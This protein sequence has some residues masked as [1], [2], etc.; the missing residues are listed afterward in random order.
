LVGGWISVVVGV[1]GAIM[2]FVGDDPP[3]GFDDALGASA[4]GVAIALPGILA[5]VALRRKPSLLVAG[6]VIALP[7]ALTSFVTFLPMLAVAVLL[8]LAVVHARV[9]LGA[10]PVASIVLASVLG[11]GAFLALFAADDPVCWATL[12]D[13]STVELSN[14]ERFV[15]GNVISMGGRDLPPGT[16]ESGCSSDSITPV[17]ALASLLLAAGAVALP[18]AIAT[19]TAPTP[20]SVGAS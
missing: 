2:R 5:F 15:R 3:L 10:R 8:F 14:P 17:E 1:A 9:P 18:A 19:P 4:L 7:L 6:A 20:S 12:S 13:G 16:R 11:I